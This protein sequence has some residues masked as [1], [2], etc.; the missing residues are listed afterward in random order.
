MTA[1]VSSRAILIS[2]T[3]LLF[4]ACGQTR[5]PYVSAGGMPRDIVKAEALYQEAVTSIDKNDQDAEKLLRKAL[6]FDLYHGSAH[7]NLGV[8]LLRQGL[9]YEAAGEFEWARKLLPG[10]PE[11]RINLAI[12][13]AQGGRSSDA[14]DAA[15]SAL[16]VRPGH[17]PALQAIAWIQF[18]EGLAD[19]KTL[20]D[21]DAIASRS[22]DPAWREWALDRR[23]VL[24]ARLHPSP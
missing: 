17:L 8:L 23:S 20:D 1:C 5:G 4:A 6:S 24:A 13:L 19:A 15:R 3:V 16:E 12:V 21:L 10:H 7:N 18:S 14:L 22:D 9:P 2:A 11:P